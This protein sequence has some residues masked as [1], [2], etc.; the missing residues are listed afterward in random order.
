MSL[1]LYRLPFRFEIGKNQTHPRA[2]KDSKYKSQETS[3]WTHLSGLATDVP[4]RVTHSH[5]EASPPWLTPYE[6]D[7][8]NNWRVP[9]SL[10]KVIP[11]H[12]SL[13]LH[14]KWGLQ[15]DNVLQGQPLHPLKHALQI[16]TEASKDLVPSGK[17]VIPKLELKVVFLALKRV[18]RSLLKQHGSHSYRKHNSDFLYKQ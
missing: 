2:L 7:L 16:L 6:A 17:Q 4:N 5:R 8:K 11:I 13:H 12:S 15:E 18:Q 3:L 1:R 9:E 14:L 10:E